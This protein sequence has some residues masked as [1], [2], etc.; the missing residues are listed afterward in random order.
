MQQWALVIPATRE[1]ETGEWFEPREKKKNWE[2]WKGRWLS[3]ENGILKLKISKRELTV[4]GRTT[5]QY[6]SAN[7]RGHEWMTVSSVKF[8]VSW[9]PKYKIST[10][11]DK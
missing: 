4:K 1:D 9:L 11:I 8:N 2:N 10:L 7:Q 6:T 3:T 5:C